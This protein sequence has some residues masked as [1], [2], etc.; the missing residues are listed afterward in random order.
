MDLPFEGD[1][2]QDPFGA[3]G[4]TACASHTALLELDTLG[5][6]VAL[7]QDLTQDLPD[8]EKLEKVIGLRDLWQQPARKRP[9][10]GV[11]RQI[12]NWDAQATRAKL[13][14]T[15]AVQRRLRQVTNVSGK[16]ITVLDSDG[17]LEERT[18]AFRACVRGDRPVVSVSASGCFRRWLATGDS[19]ATSLSIITYIPG[20]PLYAATVT[21]NTALLSDCS[22]SWRLTLAD[23]WQAMS[24]EPI[25]AEPD[26]GFI[27]LPRSLEHLAPGLRKHYEEPIF[28]RDTSSA[29]AQAVLGGAVPVA[30]HFT[31]HVLNSAI[32]PV[33]VGHGMVVRVDDGQLIEKPWDASRHL[34]KAL[35]GEI[36]FGEEHVIAR[37]MWAIHRVTRVLA[38]ERQL[39]EDLHPLDAGLAEDDDIFGFRFDDDLDQED[40]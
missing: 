16:P 21:V 15:R 37:D 25:V 11:P 39:Q 35:T 38:H 9:P 7:G 31:E 20:R 26:P 5:R 29:I 36:A 4:I 6:E 3:D 24:G 34:Y 28:P 13:R 1:G 14:I 40:D 19:T 32:F 33:A 17:T 18:D 23:G 2:L 8:D 30:V 22:G 27:V 10:A 12:G